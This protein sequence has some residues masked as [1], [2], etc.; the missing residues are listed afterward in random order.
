MG[1]LD[2]IEKAINERGT[3]VIMRE[4]LDLIRE[5]V[6]SLENKIA[7][8][9]QENTALKQR[10]AELQRDAASHSAGEDFIKHRGA[11]FKR[12]PGGGYDSSVF[13]R[14]CHEPMFSLEGEAPFHC[15]SCNV[16]VDFTRRD[17]PSVMREL[18]D[19]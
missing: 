11:F 7:T 17:L 8:L 6:Q 1:L 15:A 13:C 9:Q 14:S 19:Q 16:M 12:K 5:Q 2:L 3:A 18:H 10:V 4:R